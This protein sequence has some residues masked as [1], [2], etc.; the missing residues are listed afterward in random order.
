[1]CSVAIYTWLIHLCISQVG[2]YYVQSEILRIGNEQ[3]LDNLEE[4]V[5]IQNEENLDIIFINQAAKQLG[6]KKE[7]KEEKIQS[8]SIIEELINPEF[9]AN[10]KIFV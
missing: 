6:S 3:L 4:G 1:M 2:L 5:V 7:Q 9:E 8:Q 10:Q